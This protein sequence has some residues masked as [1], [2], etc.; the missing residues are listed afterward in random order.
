MKCLYA[1]HWGDGQCWRPWTAVMDNH[2]QPMPWAYT[3]HGSSPSR[4]TLP[5]AATSQQGSLQTTD[6]GQA[7][8]QAWWEALWCAADS[9]SDARWAATTWTGPGL[10][11]SRGEQGWPGS[12]PRL[13]CTAAYRA[14]TLGQAAGQCRPSRQQQRGV[15]LHAP[16]HLTRA[17]K[18]LYAAYY[19]KAKWQR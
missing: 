13:H 17:P 5:R 7:A 15:I 16:T 19:N 1:I 8:H 18:K 6:P 9:Q 11:T 3:W 14:G 4:G 12:P 10:V 2:G